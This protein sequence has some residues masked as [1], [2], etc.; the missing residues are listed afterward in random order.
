MA[1]TAYGV[2]APEAVKLWRKVLY[3]E[4]LAATWVGKFMGES[5]ENVLQILDDTRKSAGDRVTVTLR[6]QLTGDG[7]SGDATMEGNEEALVTYTD[8]LFIDQLRNAVR[9]GG[10]MT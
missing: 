2:N 8:N 9:S 7:V 6:M 4:A 10:K 3:E 5:S 1:T